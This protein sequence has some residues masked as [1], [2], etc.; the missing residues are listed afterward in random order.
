VV[1]PILQVENLVTEFSTPSGT[2][3]AVEGVNFKIEKGK[4]LGIV[5][6]S[7]CGKSVTALSIM[8]LLPL[9]FAK[10]KDGKIL[11]K[12]ENL[13]TRSEKDMQKIRGKHIAMVFQEPMTSLNPVFTIGTQISEMVRLHLQLNRSDAKHRTIELLQR[14]G[15]PAPER[16]VDEYPHQLSGGMRQ[17]VMIAMAISCNPDLIIADEPTT[18]LDV[19]IQAQILALLQD[20]R[21]Q[22]GMAMILISHDLGVIAEVAE[23]VVIM[24]AGRIVEQAKTEDLFAIPRHPYTKGLLDSLPRFEQGEVKTRLRT[25]KGSVPKLTDLPSGCKFSTR[26]QWVMDRCHTE[27]PGLLKQAPQHFSR[28]WLEEPPK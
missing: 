3:K 11:F 6:E 5:G 8:R 21:T 7:G 10:I 24:Y 22:I 4:V 2:L 12:G 1:G 18:A 25:I 9:P 27:E 23:E 26:C 20:L 13:L 14:V 16:R 15:I 17:R 28:C 19:T